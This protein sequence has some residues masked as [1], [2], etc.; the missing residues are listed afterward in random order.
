MVDQEIYFGKEK[1]TLVSFLSGVSLFIYL[2]CIQRAK[3]TLKRCLTGGASDADVA[4]ETDELPPTSPDACRDMVIKASQQQMQSTI[5]CNA[6][7]ARV[8]QQ[9][10]LLKYLLDQDTAQDS[11]RLVFS[12]TDRFYCFDLHKIIFFTVP[13][14]TAFT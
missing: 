12:D 6:V 8:E 3:E 10:A 5:S 14:H 1:Y 11:D 2:F 9:G 13:F 7:L 4:M